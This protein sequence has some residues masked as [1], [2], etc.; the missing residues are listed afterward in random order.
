LTALR[1]SK[2][3]TLTA[4]EN[5]FGQ[6]RQFIGAMATLGLV[7]TG[8]LDHRSAGPRDSD[9]NVRR[10]GAKGDGKSDDTRAIQSAIDA[11]NGIVYFP[12]GVYRITRTIDI[13]L[14]KLG[15]TAIYGDG[16]A[17]IVMAGAGPAFRF[18]GTHEKSADPKGFADNVWTRQRM[19]VVDNIGI[20][21]DHPES[22]G[23]EAVGTMQ[24][25][26]TRLHVR[27]ALHGIHLRGNNRNLAVADCHLY[28]NRG[29]GS[30]YDDVNL[31]QSNITGCHISYNG[32]GGI[33]SRGGNVRNIHI[34]GCDI[35]SN[36]GRDMPATANVLIDCSTSQ[37]GTAE[38]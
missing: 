35:E 32:G 13:E 33:V 14:D 31:H 28:E 16:T 26:I 18:R 15:F 22:V 10:Y 36:M 19:P 29:I 30:F 24:L 6:R 20:V 5:Q 25:T 37:W 3:L 7:T 12:K 27:K 21:G 8:P 23:V 4:M 11:A 1:K 34:T 17:A 38:V 9:G 2:S